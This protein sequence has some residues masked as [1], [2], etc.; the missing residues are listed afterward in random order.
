MYST[1]FP[2]IQYR[3]SNDDPLPPSDRL[4]A[5]YLQIGDLFRRKLQAPNSGQA[6]TRATLLSPWTPVAGT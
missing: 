1:I 2:P 6:Q 5:S 4:L 3:A